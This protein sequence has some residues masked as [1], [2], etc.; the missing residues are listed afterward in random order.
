MPPRAAALVAALLC[1]PTALAQ[2]ASDAPVLPRDGSPVTTSG[3]VTGF[4]GV[5][6]VM[7]VEAGEQ[8]RVDFT[9]AN[10]DCRLSVL[11]DGS[12]K[13]IYLSEKDGNQ[14]AAMPPAPGNYVIHVFQR[15]NP[16]RRGK[17]CDF[18]I[19]FSAAPR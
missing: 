8:I 15:P 3:R 10:R 7:A 14:F 4:N 16:A 18:Q 12:D 5:R 13:P 1:A 6:Y 11:A 9:P 19:S 2:G 17:S